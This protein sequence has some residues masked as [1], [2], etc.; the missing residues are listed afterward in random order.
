MTFG[1]LKPT[2]IIYDTLLYSS[3]SHSLS[4]ADFHPRILYL[5]GTQD[6]LAKVTKA[7]RVYFSK[8]NEEDEEN[9]LVDHSIVLYLIGPDGSFL[10]FFTQSMQPPDIVGRIK[11]L[12]AQACRVSA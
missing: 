7:Y 5:T 4:N 11:N 2:L 1:A 9:Y 12:L 3:H 8:A 6:Q 10:D